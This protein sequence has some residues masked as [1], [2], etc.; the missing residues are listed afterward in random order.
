[1][2]A[3]VTKQ[4]QIKGVCNKI[5][6]DLIRIR[7]EANFTQ[8]FMADWLGVSRKKLNEFEGGNFDFDLMCLY[9]EKLSVDLKLNYEIN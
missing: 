6:T 2:E 3:D 4:L 5:V 1:M 7:K 8:D 9:C